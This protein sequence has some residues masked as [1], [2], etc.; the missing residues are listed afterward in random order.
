M[1]RRR[2][3]GGDGLPRAVDPPRRAVTGFTDAEDAELGLTRH[4]L[5]SVEQ[6]LAGNGAHF[7]RS[8]RNWE[9]LVVQDGPLFTGQNPASAAALAEAFAEHVRT[10]PAVAAATASGSAASR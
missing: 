8:T 3:P 4:V 7:R 6:A 9:P 5:F 10:R 1:G 2:D